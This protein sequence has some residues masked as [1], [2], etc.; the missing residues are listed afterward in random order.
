MLLWLP[1]GLLAQ[2]FE[3]DT[4]LI[5]MGTGFSL[6]AVA[7]TEDKAQRA[8][9]K[10]VEEVQRL[11]RMISSHLPNSETT[12]I[13]H[14]AGLQPVKVSDEL[15]GLIVRSKKISEL[16]G[17]AFDISFAPLHH[18]WKFTG[19]T[20]QMPHPDTV[21]QY[22]SL[23]NWQAIQTNEAD[24][25]VFLTQKGMAIGFGSIGKGL[26]ANKA[27][28]VMMDEGASSGFVNAS[29]DI[30]FWGKPANSET[31]TVGI[32]HPIQKN[33]YLGWLHVHNMAVVTSGNYEKYLTVEGKRLSHIIDPRSGYPVEDASSV[34]IVC[35]D[36]ELADA[37][38]TGVS[39]LGAT[40]GIE[41]VN[42]LKNVECL[43]INSK[44]E[45]FQSKNLQLKRQVNDNGN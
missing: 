7:D 9:I 44:G 28:M 27:K 24:K 38:A 43:Y 36:A 22:K 6:K 1:S 16:T 37:L 20:G 31:W 45:F 3:A 33:H 10:G 14:N 42:R 5:L 12:L 40:K 13:N 39:V 25:K 30:L 32:T 41:L 23:V 29:G 8:V 17:G 15:F 2:A 18:V 4:S 26:A 11:E 35:P 21:S 34:T 19:Q